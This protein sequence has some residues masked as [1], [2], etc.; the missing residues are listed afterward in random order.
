MEIPGLSD[1]AGAID[2]RKSCPAVVYLGAVLRVIP[3]IF[4]F[5]RDFRRRAARL[6]IDHLADQLM[7][8]LPQFAVVYTQPAFPK[9][10][11]SHP[12]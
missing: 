2:G 6:R 12:Q 5:S 8:L 11:R 1:R 4:S 7:Q 10:N 3:T 9:N